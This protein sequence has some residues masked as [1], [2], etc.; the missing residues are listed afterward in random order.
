[1]HGG[2]HLAKQGIPYDHTVV[3][4][5][6][7][8]CDGTYTAEDGKV[9]PL[10]TK[11]QRKNSN[12]KL[13]PARIDTYRGET[14]S[15][16]QSQSCAPQ[17]GADTCCDTCDYEVAVNVS[18]YGVVAPLDE[19][20]PTSPLI[21]DARSATRSSARPRATST[22][23]ART[24]SRTCTAAR[25]SAPS[26][27]TGTVIPRAAT[28]PS[29]SRCRTSC[30]RRT[31]MSAGRGTSSKPSPCNDDADCTS[32]TKAFLAGMECVGELGAN[33]PACNTGDD[34]INKRCVAEWFGD[35]RADA[36]TTGEQG[37]LRRQA[38]ERR[39]QRRLLHQRRG[40]LYLY[41]ARDLSG[42]GLGDGRTQGKGSRF[43][44]AD[45]NFDGTVEAIE[46][47]RTSL[48][49]A[50]KEAAIPSISRV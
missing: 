32:D 20:T 27:T 31:P 41:V 47:C 29:T 13:E 21:N 5:D 45:S 42:R 48:G 26:H 35:C 4:N 23:S 33:G 15:R 34:C 19:S 37:L 2:R 28:R 18:K 22:P 36:K 50:D 10:K 38:L 17:S 9:W 12:G 3:K 16:R 46:G 24:S 1:M 7:T 40:L 30:A 39:G 8:I 6:P 44:L 11:F 14:D 43:S 25:S 49:G